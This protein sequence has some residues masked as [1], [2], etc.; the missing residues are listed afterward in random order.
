M[1]KQLPSLLLLLLQPFAACRAGGETS[2]CMI[3][4]VSGGW[5]LVSEVGLCVVVLR[6]LW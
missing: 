5:C 2:C 4:L 3:W 6:L 1:S